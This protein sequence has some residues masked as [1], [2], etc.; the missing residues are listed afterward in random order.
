MSKTLAL[1]TSVW[2]CGSTDSSGPDPEDDRR[3][4]IVGGNNQT[5]EVGA[6]LPAPLT[7]RV[8]AGS[9]LVP[10]VTVA[11]VVPL[12]SWV[13]IQFRIQRKLA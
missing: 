13:L 7:V 2:A 5:G 9:T 10:G 4:A 3:L 8:A 11:F 1:L 6:P 12:P